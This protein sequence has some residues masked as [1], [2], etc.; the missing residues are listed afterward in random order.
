[1][2]AR[3]VCVR[4]VDR[5]AVAI[6]ANSYGSVVMG[7]ACKSMSQITRPFTGAGAPATHDA[8]RQQVLYYTHARLTTH[9]RDW[10]QQARAT[11]ACRS[12]AYPAVLGT[13]HTCR[14]SRRTPSRWDQPSTSAAARLKHHQHHQLSIHQS[15]S[16][17]TAEPVVHPSG[18]GGAIAPPP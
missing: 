9:V 8:A 12:R 5:D 15:A 4:Y 2:S 18:R 6:S 11:S 17:A 3:I 16:A 1:M 10:L 13:I 14:G 7:A